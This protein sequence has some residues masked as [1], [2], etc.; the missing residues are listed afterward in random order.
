MIQN[1]TNQ[2]IDPNGIPVTSDPTKTLAGRYLE[3]R[4]NTVAD[5]KSAV[6]NSGDIIAS[7]QKFNFDGIEFM[8]AREVEALIQPV[9]AGAFN[10]VKVIYAR[11]APRGTNIHYAL[12]SFINFTP[13]AGKPV[14]GRSAD[15]PH[16]TGADLSNQFVNEARATVAGSEKP[17]PAAND[18][19]LDTIAAA[20]AQAEQ[21][22]RRGPGRPKNPPTS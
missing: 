17:V 10:N 7:V 2:I 19:E 22:A 21:P 8:I 1:T 4:L 11:I 12:P 5:A 9:I 14:T 16:P 13:G 15:E 20:N 18:T 3:V 6:Q